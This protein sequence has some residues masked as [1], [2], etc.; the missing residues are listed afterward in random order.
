MSLSSAKAKLDAQGGDPAT[1]YISKTDHKDS[2]TE[3]LADTALTGDTTAAALDVTGAL[4]AGTVASDGTVAGTG[5]AGG[6]LSAATPVINGTAAAGTSAVPSRDDHVHASDTTKVTGPASSTDNALV[7]FDGTDGKTV[8]NSGITVD[9]SGN[10]TTNLTVSKASPSMS[11]DAAAGGQTGIVYYK[12]AGVERWRLIKTGTAESGSNAGS[13]F[14]LNSY[15]DAGAFLSTDVGVDRAT[16]KATLG[17]VGATA[18]LEL[19][20]SGPRIMSGTGSPEGVVSAPVGSQWTDTAATTGA[21]QWIK[22]TGTGNT[23]WVVQYGDTGW[24]NVTA[25]MEAGFK[26][27]NPN[28]ALYVRRTNDRVTW[29]LNETIAGSATGTVA[30][31]VPPTGFK[32]TVGS[33]PV[34]VHCINA[35]T[36]TGLNETFYFASG[37]TLYGFAWTAIRHQSLLSY[38]LASSTAWPTSLPGT[39]A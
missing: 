10:F 9:D 15:S 13:N 26:T 22:A 18:G 5:L 36:G 38:P 23:G 27:S 20:A 25:S 6:L 21:I 30:I 35:N 14:A 16:G 37:T 1:G 17:R 2:Y 34:G 19:G 29:M 7:R 24:R 31:Y 12:T 28:A 4:T 8:Q 11:I 39:A 33:I 32:E 3:L